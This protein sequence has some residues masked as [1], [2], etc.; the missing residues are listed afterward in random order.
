MT[1]KYPHLLPRRKILQSIFSF[2]GISN[3]PPNVF[4][5]SEHICLTTQ[6]RVYPA[7]VKPSSTALAALLY[8]LWATF[9]SITKSKSQSYLPDQ[10]SLQLN[11]DWLE[12]FFKCIFNEE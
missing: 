8:Q 9:K 2:S 1:Q 11:I 6:M 10:K 7:K 3:I 5:T 12:F 4:P